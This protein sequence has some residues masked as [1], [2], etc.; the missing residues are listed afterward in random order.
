MHIIRV[1]NQ[2]ILLLSDT[3]GKHRLIDIPKNIQIVIH[4]GDICNAGEIND[5]VDFFDW[6]AQLEI[7]HKVFVHGNHDLPFEL[8]LEWGKRLIPKN[9]IWLNDEAITIRN[10]NIMGISAFPFHNS[11]ETKNKID[12]IVSHYPPFGILDN[13]FGSEE[14]AE[15]IIQFAPK[16]HVFGHNHANCGKIKYKNIQYINASIYHKLCQK[17]NQ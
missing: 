8:E 5:V 11:I 2:N 14:V 7:P 6:Y 15:F 3:H 10:I 13:G 17:E 16:Y 12:I 9:I 4:C 1:K